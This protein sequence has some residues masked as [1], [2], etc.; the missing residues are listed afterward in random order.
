MF[1]QVLLPNL[2]LG[3][4][5]SCLPSKVGLRPFCK[6]ILYILLLFFFVPSVTQVGD[7]VPLDRAFACGSCEIPSNW[8]M[9][10][11]EQGSFGKRQAGNLDLAGVLW[12]GG[13]FGFN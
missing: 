10:A 13:F 7:S 5:L 4:L 6:G 8:G 11:L 3:V 1:S 9:Q 12:V 2:L